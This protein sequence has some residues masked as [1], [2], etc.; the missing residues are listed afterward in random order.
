M[1]KS[2]GLPG[3]FAWREANRGAIHYYRTI[4]LRTCRPRAGFLLSEL[5]R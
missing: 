1:N 5:R 3:L 4:P 2:P